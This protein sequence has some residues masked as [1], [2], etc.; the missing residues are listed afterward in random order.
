LRGRGRQFYVTK[1]NGGAL[2]EEEDKYEFSGAQ[3][4]LGED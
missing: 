3:V 1:Y 2:R 4:E